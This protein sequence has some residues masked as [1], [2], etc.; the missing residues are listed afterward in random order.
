MRIRNQ[1]VAAI[2][3]ALE[4]GE[5]VL[6]IERQIADGCSL[7]EIERA[8]TGSRWRFH[9]HKSGLRIN[10]AHVD[11]LRQAYTNKLNRLKSMCGQLVVQDR[12]LSQPWQS[13]AQ[14]RVRTQVA[15]QARQV[16]LTAERV[17]RLLSA[18]E[19][20]NTDG[21]DKVCQLL[22]TFGFDWLG[23]DI[24][25]EAG[26]GRLPYYWGFVESDEV[27]IPSG[28]PIMK[29]ENRKL[30]SALITAAKAKDENKVAV[31]LNR[32][33]QTG[34]PLREIAD[35]LILTD[36]RYEIVGSGHSI[37]V[38]NFNEL[39]DHF[40]WHCGKVVKLKMMLCAGGPITD[41]RSLNIRE[42]LGFACKSLAI[43]TDRFNRYLLPS[44]QYLDVSDY[45]TEFLKDCDFR[46]NGDYE[47]ERFEGENE[48][49]L[50]AAITYYRSS[51]DADAPGVH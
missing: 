36:Y 48:R 32:A 37:A 13:L 33:L 6:I 47:V 50:E 39:H 12:N 20:F 45:V 7:Q 30:L 10:V 19:R 22:R 18:D 44:E 46:W 24:V 9:L 29:A 16:R 27:A 34:V 14:T 49:L 4:S 17:N 40:A 42:P 1:V 23:G 41:F 8:F 21:N 5:R 28:P 43:A 35:T 38:Q 51:P 3:A 25:D 11:D 31:K 26:S 2:K 15:R